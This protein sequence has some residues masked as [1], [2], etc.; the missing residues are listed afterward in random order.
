MNNR[1]KR[2]LFWRKL[3]DRLIRLLSVAAVAVAVL[4]MLWI[5]ASV[6]RRG[7]A[8]IDLTFLLEPSKP[9]G[10]PDGGIAN[11]LLGT[12]CITLTAAILTI[13]PGIL[14]GIALAEF[15]R[16]SRTGHLI[17]FAANVMMGIPS[18]IVGLFVYTLLVVPMGAASGL[19]GSVA[20]G[21]I[22]FPVVMRT[23]EDMLLLVPDS[24]REAGLALGMTRC[25]ATLC[26]IFRA[27]K[28]GLITG[29]LLALARVTGETAPLLFTAQFSNY[30]PSGF[31]S[32]PTANL[33]VLIN[34][35]TTNSPYESMHAAGWG[36]ALV[37]TVI[38]L[39]LNISCR[40]LFKE[41]QHG[42]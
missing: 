9:A 38:I 30:W 10:V 32:G 16:D 1:K 41:K 18:I 33:P 35:Y 37:V 8:V 19:A 40:V 39:L 34:E 31:F 42:R 6:V 14:G 5:L 13:P 12:V 17:R 24:L 28:S 15:G 25:R 2:P 22:M 20:L 7:A 27:S 4:A 26:I 21:I 23:T 29:I 11:A 3:S 36:A